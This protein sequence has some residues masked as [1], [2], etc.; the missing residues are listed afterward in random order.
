MYELAKWI[1]EDSKQVYYPIIM[2]CRLNLIL[3]V[4]EMLYIG[5]GKEDMSEF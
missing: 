4:I 2:V 1:R 5:A 3:L